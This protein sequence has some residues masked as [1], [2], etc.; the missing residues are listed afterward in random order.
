M[1]EGE[2]G[3]REGGGVR[4]SAHQ[5]EAIK[6]AAMTAF[7]EGTIVRL[8]GS[9]VDD[10]RKG[11]DIDLHIETSP[12]SADVDHEVKFRSLVW[13]ALDE[14]QIDVVVAAHG[15]DRWIDRAALRE[16]VVL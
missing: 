10:D 9:R 16:G 14:E 11:G 12:T 15:Q 8:F 1:A 4:L 13:Q 2:G 5:A 6:Q 3:E 7:G